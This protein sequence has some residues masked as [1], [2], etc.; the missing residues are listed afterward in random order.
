[1]KLKQLAKLSLFAV[2]MNGG[3]L[4]AQTTTIDYTNQSLSGCNV[5]GNGVNVSSLLHKCNV[6]H[7]WLSG[8]VTLFGG[9]DV[10]LPGQ[11]I[12]SEYEISYPFAYGHSYRINVVGTSQ[13]PSNSIQMR[14]ELT[15]PS[16]SSST[17]CAYGVVS[18]SPA[19]SYYT[20]F[21]LPWD[22]DVNFS[23]DFSMSSAQS[24]LRLTLISNPGGPLGQEGLIKKIIIQDISVNPPTFL[25]NATSSSRVCLTN[26]PITFTI[27]NVNNTPG[28]T[29][30]EF[31]V[32][33]SKWKLNGATPPTVI[34]QASNSL[35]LTPEYCAS[36]TTVTA[37]ALFGSQFSETNSKTISVTVPPFSISGSDNVGSSAPERY[38]LLPNPSAYYPPGVIA[39]LIPDPI[40]S[41]P[42]GNLQVDIMPIGRMVDVYRKANALGGNVVLTATVSA[43]DASVAINKTVNVSFFFSGIGKNINLPF[44]LN[45]DQIYPNPSSGAFNLRLNKVVDDA[46]LE[47]HS[48]DGKS[49][50]KKTIS[51]KSVDISIP[52]VSAGTYFIKI[53]DGPNT[54]TQ[55]IIKE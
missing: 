18:S 32:V 33:P 11:T 26:N 21:N 37:K 52:E 34:T 14:M 10:T 8:G 25:L 27:Q 50:M 20:T 7:Q 51:G 47:I 36:Y 2:A 29:G 6:G 39:C 43:C 38:T 46:T 19:G 30:Y 41:V 55:K 28:V 17:S 48:V 22:S 44:A 53:T 35:T 54:A 15:G 45:I 5:F 40:W 16:T 31:R 23:H 12:G 13:T 3:L 49:V 42:P 1:M 24:R 4:R 9:T